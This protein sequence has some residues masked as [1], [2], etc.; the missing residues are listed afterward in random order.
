[1]F[2][3]LCVLFWPLEDQVWLRERIIFT[4]WH[5]GFSAQPSCNMSKGHSGVEY[6]GSMYIFA[7]Y[8]GNYRTFQRGEGGKL[9]QVERTC[10]T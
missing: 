8:D 1:M 2:R 7:G 5:G 9:S 4:P 10:R 3:V 6:D